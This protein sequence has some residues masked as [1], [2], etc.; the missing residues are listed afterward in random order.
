MDIH[1]RYGYEIQHEIAFQKNRKGKLRYSE[2]IVDYIRN[3]GRQW[4]SAWVMERRL[5]TIKYEEE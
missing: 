1:E 3:S 2:P 5:I 4:T